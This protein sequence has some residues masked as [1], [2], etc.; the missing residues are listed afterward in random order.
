MGNALAELEAMANPASVNLRAV[1]IRIEVV[2]ASAERRGKTEH[3][4]W[5]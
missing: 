1:S 4:E 5:L 2:L 3:K